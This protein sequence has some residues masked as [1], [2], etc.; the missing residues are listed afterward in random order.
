MLSNNCAVVF[1][2]GFTLD[3]VRILMFHVK[4]GGSQQ[5]PFF[6]VW[7]LAVANYPVFHVKHGTFMEWSGDGL[8][9]PGW[10]RWRFRVVKWSGS[11]RCDTL[12]H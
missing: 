8:Q 6:L 7:W 11:G 4:H 12:L 9:D 5:A 1:S 2:V 10:E 3:N